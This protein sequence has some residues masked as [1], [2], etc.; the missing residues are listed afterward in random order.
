[1]EK[2]ISLKV[3]LCFLI[4]MAIALALIG[5]NQDDGNDDDT[6]YDDRCNY[7]IDGSENQDQK[8]FSGYGKEDVE[9]CL[10]DELPDNVDTEPVIAFLEAYLGEYLDQND[11]QIT[12]TC[13][14]EGV[15]KFPN[16]DSDPSVCVYSWGMPV[17]IAFDE[18]DATAIG[19]V[20]QSYFTD[21]TGDLS[22][23][24][25]WPEADLGFAKDGIEPG[26]VKQWSQDDVLQWRFEC[27]I[28]WAG[29]IWTKVE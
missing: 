10:P 2:G 13:R 14:P 9:E 15:W 18:D 6:E 4:A 27:P 23:P 25:T 22:D 11:F 1:M 7:F 21:L 29:V 24:T 12:I 5:C 17:W 3:F 16:P 19:S 20:L 26:A 8:R 28:E